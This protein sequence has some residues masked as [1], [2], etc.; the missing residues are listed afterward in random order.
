MNNHPADRIA[1][2]LA[3]KQVA[4]CSL[5]VVLVLSVFGC[6]I[7]REKTGNLLGKMKLPGKQAKSNLPKS[8]PT[9][10][11]TDA[12]A[13]ALELPESDLLARERFHQRFDK[14]LAEGRTSAADLLV[15][16][17]PDHAYETLCGHWNR[18]DPTRP[19][20]AAA[21]D[22]FC[23]G[24]GQWHELMA[25]SDIESV[26]RYFQDR[27]QFFGAITNGQFEGTQSIDLVAKAKATGSEALLVD[28]WY[29]T[30]VAKLLLQQN[31][32]AA[33]AFATC[34]NI[35]NDRHGMQSA[36]AMLMCG[37]AKRRA[38]DYVDATQAWR[39]SVQIA[40]QQV[41]TRNLT[42]PG[43]WD[44]AIYLQPVGTSWP[45]EVATTFAS[46][47]SRPASV[48]R[49]DLLQQLAAIKHQSDALP[50]GCWIEA[51]LAS[52]RDDRG[53]QQKALIH[54]KKAE[55][56]SVPAAVDWLRIAQAPMLV[57]LGQAGMATTLLAPIIAREDD[58]PQMLA[59]MSKLGVIKLTGVSKQHGIRLLHRAVVESGGTQWPGKAAA[60]ADLA[61]GLLM[62]G[63]TTQGLQQLR[64]AQQQFQ[65]D[66]EI[67][68]LAKSL[69]NEQRYLEHS[70][71]NK[72][73]IAA[74]ESRLQTMRL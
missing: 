40:C 7:S 50:A 68:Q 35:A 4:C 1:H 70:D 13:L 59:A 65:A 41:Q 42:D 69:W 74:V 34:S 8:G 19:A 18:D 55:T 44:R 48:L 32:A 26:D 15:A 29:Q 5:L 43:Y 73:E 23:G 57:S 46:I 38:S 61:L 58:S 21:Y 66:G 39:Q 6:N 28:A 47:G 49:S 9:K 10:V 36:I 27:K 53:E 56:L 2:D 16:R 3:T 37:E 17:H 14:L 54:L 60:R 12:T 67:E 63:E 31:A 62:I 45:A 30:G 22:R 20:L 33:E 11:V 71:A 51:A 72:Q 64:Q 24:G 25:S 52:W